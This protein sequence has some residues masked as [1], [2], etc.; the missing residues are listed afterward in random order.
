MD[1]F[2][3]GFYFLEW[4]DIKPSLLILGVMYGIKTPSQGF[5]EALSWKMTF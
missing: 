1:F 2:Y 5:H 4:Y 3:Q